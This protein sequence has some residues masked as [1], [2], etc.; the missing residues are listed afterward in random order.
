MKRQHFRRC[1]AEK[2]NGAYLTH[3]IVACTQTTVNYQ[4]EIAIHIPFNVT[5]DRVLI[6]F[7]S[8]LCVFF[9]LSYDTRNA[10]APIC[11]QDMHDFRFA[12]NDHHQAAN[13]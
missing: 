4:F 2:E 11:V 12:A 9:T 6:F 10:F 5:T 13:S 1:R 8:L 7:R 3:Q